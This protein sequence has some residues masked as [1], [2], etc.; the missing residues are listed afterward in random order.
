M[1]DGSQLTLIISLQ[2]S[3]RNSVTLGLSR[4]CFLMSLV[5]VPEPMRRVVEGAVPSRLMIYANKWGG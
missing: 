3:R 2:G 1:T 4:N 5:A